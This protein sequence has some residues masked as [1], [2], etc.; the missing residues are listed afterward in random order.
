MNELFINWIGSFKVPYECDKNGVY[1]WYF[2]DGEK[3]VPTQKEVE[4]KKIELD[5]KWESLKYQRDRQYPP[6][7]EQLD[8]IYWDKKNDTKKWEEA[9]DKVKAD[10][11][12]PE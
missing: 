11:P 12:K 3:K 6:Q 2:N 4:N 7:N 9:I 5:K 1:I 10:H 8:M